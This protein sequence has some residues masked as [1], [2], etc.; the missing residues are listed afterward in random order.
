MKEESF[1]TLSDCRQLS[2]LWLSLLDERRK[3][4]DFIRLPTM[5]LY[6]S[7]GI[8]FTSSTLLSQLFF[9]FANKYDVATVCFHVC[10]KFSLFL[11]KKYVDLQFVFMSVPGL[12]CFARNIML[13]Q[14]FLIFAP[15]FLCFAKNYVVSAISSYV[16]PKIPLFLQK[17][18]CFCNFLLCLSQVFKKTYYVDVICF[19]SILHW[20]IFQYQY[21]TVTFEL[22]KQPLKFQIRHQKNVSSPLGGEMLQGYFFPFRPTVTRKNDLTE[23]TK[24]K[25]SKYTPHQHTGVGNC[26]FWAIG[27]CL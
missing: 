23:N 10:P 8:L 3:F 13:L 4:L 24:K 1:L 11:Q 22:R 2:F 9:V 25:G 20:Q 18:C 26:H 21:A 15:R 17:I 5:A 14:F 19:I 7:L 27:F 12:L 16:C 6:W